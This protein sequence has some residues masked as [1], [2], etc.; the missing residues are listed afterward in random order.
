PPTAFWGRGE[1][2]RGHAEGRPPDR[3]LPG[4]LRPGTDEAPR[5]AR[6]ETVG[7]RIPHRARGHHRGE[8]PRPPTGARGRKGVS[9]DPLAERGTRPRARGLLQDLDRPK[10]GEADE[11]HSEAP[12]TH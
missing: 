8:S 4:V 12:I 1:S 3:P 2:A 6:R 9:L 5:P 7:R 11:R 10:S